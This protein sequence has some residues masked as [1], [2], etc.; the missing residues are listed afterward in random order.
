VSLV[1]VSKE[2]D[3]RLRVAIQKLSKKLDSGAEPT[4]AGVTLTGLTASR[5]ASTDAD[6]KLASVAN[7]ASWVAGTANE[8]DVADD[9][10]GT[11]TIGIV[12]PLIVGKGGS[13]AATFTDGGL[14]LGSGTS[15]FTA[16][17]QATNG[18]LP[19][20][21][22]GADPVLAV[23]T[24]GEG[25]DVTNAAGGITI[26]GED[27]TSSN[28]GIASFTAANLPVTAGNV[29]T[30]QGI[31]T[32][33][34]PVFAGA[35]LGNV[36][37]PAVFTAMTEPSGFVDK[38]ATLSFVDATRV[39]TITGS[40]DIY[41]NGVKTTKTTASIT[42]DDTT[43][44]HWIYYN[45][46]GTLS[47]ATTVPAFSNPFI[48]TIYY[49]TVTDKGLL[50]E[51]RHGIKMD[52]DTHTLLHHT[53]GV[54][55]ESGLAG[56]FAD[57]TFSIAAG[58]IDDEDLA[59]SITPAQTTCNVLY[60]DGAADF[61]WLAGQTKYYY[62]DGGSDLNYNDGNTLTPLAAN[63]YMAVWIFATNDT[64]TP[65]I[66]LIGQR[67]D[68]TLADARN[69]NKYESLT[70]GTLPYQEMKLLYRVILQN[71]ATPY[72]EAQDLRNIS[73]LPA[74]TYVATT[75]NAL[76]GLSYDL[77][78][79]TGFE[80]TVTKGNLTAG[81]TK[82]TIGGTGTGALI[83][84]GATVDV[85]EA[86]VVHD[87]LS[88][89]SANKHI[90]HT[91]VSITAGTGMSGG[92]TIAAD[93]TLTCTITQY[94]DALARTAC[95]ASS[96]S[97]GDTTHSPDGNSVFDALALKSPIASPTFT[98]T[99]TMPASVVIPDGGTIGQVAGPLLTF[100]D[101]NNS[102]KLTGAKLS[103]EGTTP[104][105]G[106]ST[107][108][109]AISG[110]TPTPSGIT[111]INTGASGVTGGP[112]FQLYADDGAALSDGDRLG[113][114]VAGGTSKSGTLRNSAGFVMYADG[115]WVDGSSYPSKM[116]FE[117]TNASAT[118][119]TAKMTIN[120]AGNIGI[121]IVTFGANSVTV[122]GI[123][124]GTVPAAHVDNEIQIFSVDSSDAAATLG[125][126]LEQAVEAIGTFTASNK[127]K[128]KIN[129]TEYWIQLDAV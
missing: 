24:E 69:N 102:L 11:I 14:L 56:T 82:I 9:G 22:T 26:A 77:A 78:G 81:S 88:G 107:A 39:F 127:I 67:T 76:T 95:I 100:D 109:I 51:E 120:N 103:I 55:Y 4:F 32:T 89:Y 34:S 90:D 68:T 53:V 60:K 30:I 41:I 98:G 113:Y 99:V 58:I 106:M 31:A 71:T 13:G 62:E 65:I 40:H 119:R 121:G 126:M 80:P 23:L 115:D 2:S 122:L 59:Y 46:S 54:R 94:T 91:G 129:G 124:N 5:L 83:G 116:Q 128:V 123:A 50:G 21:S 57:T 112:A 96:I 75:H 117:T 20:G 108:G 52:G 6:K 36:V 17:G 87:N 44:I 66:S 42:I 111:A 86:N 101:T 61:K 125:L 70:L 49:N 105:A 18:Q 97:D 10:D 48:A 45:S 85:S 29:N 35:T 37:V 72:V 33:D 3:P 114:F 79:H 104:S 110:A 118:S 43:G 1:T 8:V 92:G 63:K 15:A 84:A 93:R 25:I 74:G 19:I 16:L 7:L 38:T 73:N 12:N 64:T 47:Q 27:A 28:K